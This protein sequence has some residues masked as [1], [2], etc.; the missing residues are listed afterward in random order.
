[1]P[2]PDVASAGARRELDSLDEVSALDWRSFP[3]PD[4]TRQLADPITI[5][6][7][8]RKGDHQAAVPMANGTCA[9]LL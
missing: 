6:V 8:S 9:R 4:C 7:H 3:F 1:V 5:R 2:L